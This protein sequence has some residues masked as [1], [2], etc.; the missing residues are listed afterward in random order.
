MFLEF[1]ES[2]EWDKLVSQ[3]KIDSEIMAVSFVFLPHFGPKFD[4]LGQALPRGPQSSSLCF[5][6]Q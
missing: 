3:I 2:G 4:P 6:I 1:V 5:W